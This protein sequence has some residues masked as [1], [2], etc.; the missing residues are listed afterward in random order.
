MSKIEVSG[1][2]KLF[3]DG[4]SGILRA[5]DGV[6]FNA[7]GGQVFGLL[8]LNGAG[9]TT[10]LRMLATV[11]KPSE[12]TAIVGGYDIQTAPEQV[13]RHIGYLSGD[14]RLY[15]RLSARETL[16]YFGQLAGQELGAARAKADQ[17]IQRFSLSAAANR[18]VG[19][20]STGTKQRVNLARALMSDP[21]VLILDE[22]TA[23]LD[24]LGARE[25][26]RLIIEA[27]DEGRCVL[28]STHLMHEAAKLCEEV[29]VIHRGRILAE[30]S[31][32]ALTA[33]YSD[34][35]DAFAALVGAAEAGYPALGRLPDADQAEPPVQASPAAAAR[36]IIDGAPPPAGSHRAP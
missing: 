17:L 34:L 7:R 24:V 23:G 25:V 20:L 5:V 3:R 27:R 2:S 9:K 30:G 4:K 11:L 32:A 18:H 16:I 22:P 14:T 1:L 21:P 12:G 13:R 26:G 33:G 19:Q 15:D 31:P 28:L 29:A 8:G 36:V 35:E 6:S 10:T